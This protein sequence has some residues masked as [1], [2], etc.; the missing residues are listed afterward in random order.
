MYCLDNTEKIELPIADKTEMHRLQLMD[1]VDSQGNLTDKAKKFLIDAARLQ[2]RKIKKME[3]DITDEFKDNVKKYIEIFPKGASSGK[4]LRGSVNSIVPM[5]SWFFANY[6]EY[7][8]DDVLIATKRYIESIDNMTYCKTAGYFI[9]KDDKNK[10]T[11]SLL[12]DWC[13]AVGDEKT[14]ETSNPVVGFN[15]LA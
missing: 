7:S 14:D 15:R 12:S 10:N 3:S 8:W 11:I 6:P 1:Y 9:K 4:V 13:S 2:I 5:F